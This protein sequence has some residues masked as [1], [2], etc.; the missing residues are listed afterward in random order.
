[1]D[2]ETGKRVLDLIMEYPCEEIGVQFHGGEPTLEWD[3]VDRLA[4]Y[5][6]ARARATGKQLDLAVQTNG[7]LLTREIVLRC[8]KDRI[9]FGLSLDGDR[10]VH[11]LT[12]VFPDGS[13]SYEAIERGIRILREVDF[14]I[15]AVCTLTRCNYAHM[16][17]FLDS[18]DEMGAQ[19]VNLNPVLHFGR[20]L[21]HWEGISLNPTSLLE[22]HLTYL[23]HVA[24]G[25][26]R[27]LESKAAQMTGRLVTKMHPSWCRRSPCGAGR[28]FLTFGVDGSIH[29]CYDFFHHKELGLGQVS[30]VDRLDNLWL[31]NPVM[32]DLQ[33]RRPESLPGCSACA[34]VRYCE[35][36]CMLHAYSVRGRI[37]AIDPRCDFYKGMYTAILEKI[38]EAPHILDLLCPEATVFNRSYRVSPLR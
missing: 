37:D 32:R 15:A 24:K 31:K 33:T 16:A 26:A 1:M 21:D 18:L 35:A 17:R 6:L 34:Y 9:H 36:G 30:R 23:N 3:L 14:P 28:H 4:T 5:A 25:G 19:S 13:G 11:D 22:P 2:W 29:P 7:T 27:V 12:R 8:L 20:A 10:S 38:A